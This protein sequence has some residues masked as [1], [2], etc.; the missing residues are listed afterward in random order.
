MLF[1]AGG[2]AGHIHP[3]LAT[4]NALSLRQPEAQISFIGSSAGI[5]GDLI[6]DQD[7]E[8]D[9]IDAAPAPRRIGPEL[10]AT[11]GSVWHSVEQ[12]L[13]ALHKRRPD[14]VIGFGG[15]VAAPVYLA[16][17]KAR[18]PLVIHE[19]NAKAGWANQMG[20]RLTKYVGENYPGSLPHAEVVGMPLSQKIVDLDRA[21]NRH[22]ARRYF[23]FESDRPTLLVTGGSQG[24]RRLNEVTVRALESLIEAGLDV[25][26]ICGPANLADA[27]SASKSYRAVGFVEDMTQA[28]SAADFVCARAG[29]TTVAEVGL[30]GLPALFVPLPTG[31]GE[32]RL[33]AAPFVDARLA[34]QISNDDL[35]PS[36]LAA[37]AIGLADKP[38]QLIQMARELTNMVLRDGA[39]RL[40]TLIER[41][42]A[43]GQ[44]V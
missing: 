8:M 24:A 10:F 19:A 34:T 42:A 23:G 31:N 22:E 35:T 5:G 33:N 16:A 43:A 9:L 37:W 40:A 3:A 11:P 18:L 32:Q 38:A 41:A 30:L 39:Q 20:A 44:R 13:R 14:V 25:L 7:Y 28:Y 4:A 15:Y 17:K 26:H 21:K 12:S 2:T 36:V 6:S 27:P 1:A 29:A